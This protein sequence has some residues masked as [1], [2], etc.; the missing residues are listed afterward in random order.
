M[1]P[2]KLLLADKMFPHAA[3]FKFCCNY[4]LQSGVA[5]KFLVLNISVHSLSLTMIFNSG[6][7][8]PVV[9]FKKNVVQKQYGSFFATFFIFTTFLYSF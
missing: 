6:R 7:P 4:I 8:I 1:V 9:N 3:H 2:V 5:N